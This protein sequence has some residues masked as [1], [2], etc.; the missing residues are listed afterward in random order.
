MKRTNG[1]A[2]QTLPA[3]LSVAIPIRSRIPQNL[4]GISLRCTVGRVFPIAPAAPVQCVRQP[5]NERLARWHARLGVTLHNIDRLH[6]NGQ[7]LRTPVAARTVLSRA[8]GGHLPAVL[9]PPSVA[10]TGCWRN[11]PPAGPASP[12]RGQ[13]APCRGGGRDMITAI[14]RREFTSTGVNIKDS[15]ATDR[16]MTD[17]WLRCTR[18][19]SAVLVV[20]ASPPTKDHYV[21]WDPD[22]LTFGTRGCTPV[23]PPVRRDHRTAYRDA[24]GPGDPGAYPSWLFSRSCGRGLVVNR[25]GLSRTAARRSATISRSYSSRSGWV[26]PAAA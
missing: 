11:G 4:L 13:P 6:H 9:R 17:R 10:G 16:P 7:F 2:P 1:D 15:W 12:A 26:P 19:R 25:V 14:C 24:G 3:S 21:E 8:V 22:A 20:P 5:M 23:I 18:D